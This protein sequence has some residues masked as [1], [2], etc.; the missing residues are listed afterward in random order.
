MN[1]PNV[2]NKVCSK[3]YAAK[4]LALVVGIVADI[5]TYAAKDQGK[6]FMH[7]RSSVECRTRSVGCQTG[8]A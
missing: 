4:R 8:M 1:F 7:Q 3:Q 6:E 2:Y 5:Q